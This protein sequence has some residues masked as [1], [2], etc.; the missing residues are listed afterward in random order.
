MARHIRMFRMHDLHHVVVVF[1]LLF[2][3]MA[4]AHYIFA[5]D[6]NTV[7]VARQV[8]RVPIGKRPTIR[9]SLNISIVVVVNEP[10]Q[11]DEY[12]FALDTVRCYALMHNYT[13]LV[14][15]GNDYLKCRQKD[16][17]FRRH[18]VVA[19]L[20][21]STEW[22]LFIDADI[23]VVNPNRLIEEFI[24]DRYD[25]T[26]YDRFCSWEVAMG[27]YIVKNTAFSQ[28]FL[29]NF[30]NFESRLPDSFHGSDNGAIHAYLLETLMPELRPD[31]SICY[32]IWHESRGFDDLFLFEA[33]IRAVMGSKRTL[34]NVRIFRKGTGWV[35]DI[36]ITNSQWSAERDFMLHGMKES[37]R[38][39]V[40]DGLFSTLRSMVSSRFTW[41]PPL[42]KQLDVKQCA[43]G[44]AKWQYDRR[45][46]VPLAIVE[47]QL[48]DMA[49]SVE[50]RRWRALGL[51][52]GY[53]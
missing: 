39:T 20:L 13:L 32:R 50:K 30:A 49:Q 48:H 18:C 31:A 14:V 23:G 26:F 24:D 46:R 28:S 43:S 35:R 42:T 12:K 8:S 19:E 17:M 36:W 1:A 25:I 41:Y 27:S 34:D 53:L 40:P 45:L 47:K 15:N 7:H 11:L 51:V 9:R 37:D 10:S 38:S 52:Y 44:K 5:T 6:P 22:I 4:I 3:F 16:T 2:S 29:R 21:K 33:C